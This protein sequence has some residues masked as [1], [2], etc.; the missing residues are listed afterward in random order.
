MLHC[1]YKLQHL[2]G[3][4]VWRHARLGVNYCA[5]LYDVSGAYCANGHFAVQLLFTYGLI[6]GVRRLFGV[7]EK[8]KGQGMFFPELCVRRGGIFAYADD[9]RSERF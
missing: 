4:L 1:P 5:V 6:G 8:N 3:V 7:G 2:F 9:F